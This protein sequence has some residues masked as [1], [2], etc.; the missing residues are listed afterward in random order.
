MSICILLSVALWLNLD[1]QLILT[2]NGC[3]SSLAT[4]SSV[5]QMLQTF[6]NG[7]QRLGFVLFALC[8][9]CAH[10]THSGHSHVSQ[11]ETNSRT[12]CRLCAFDVA[13]M[14][15]KTSSAQMSYSASVDL[16][17]IKRGLEEKRSE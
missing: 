1:P 12:F 2:I 10:T 11:M 15:G 14:A 13:E 17:R 7:H 9:G 6:A 5:I 3:S 8:S 4:T 16:D